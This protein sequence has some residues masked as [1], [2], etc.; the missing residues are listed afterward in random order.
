M[1][2]IL[3]RSGNFSVIFACIFLLAVSASAQLS[4]RKALDI[5]N[6]EKADFSIF[7]PSNNAWYDLKSGGGG[8]VIQQFG[9]ANSD[10]PTPGDYDG[11]SRADISVWRDT[12]GVWHRLN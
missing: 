6:D 4:L 5:D 10:Y 3:T 9:L 7:R 8:F 2:N 11:D 1:K 12:D